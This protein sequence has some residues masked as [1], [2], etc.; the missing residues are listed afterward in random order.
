MQSM[1]T[2]M[3]GQVMAVWMQMPLFPAEKITHA[4]VDVTQM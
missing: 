4:R 3:L 1:W 2:A